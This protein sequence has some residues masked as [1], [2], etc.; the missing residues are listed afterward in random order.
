[1]ESVS[2]GAF[3]LRDKAR[4]NA[5]H[6]ISEMRMWYQRDWTEWDDER[7]PPADALRDLEMWEAADGWQCGLY[8]DED[9]GWR[10]RRWRA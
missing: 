10:V 2:R 8:L 5:M 6:R 9:F 7:Q 4:R 3:K 1:M